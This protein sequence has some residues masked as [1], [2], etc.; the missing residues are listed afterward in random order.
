VVGAD[1]Q[2]DAPER[3][4]NSEHAGHERE[5]NCFRNELARQ[6]PPRSAQRRPDRHFLAPSGGADEEQ[7]RHVGAGDHQ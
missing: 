7:I 3:E 4:Q 1:D 2:I 5:Q 6:P